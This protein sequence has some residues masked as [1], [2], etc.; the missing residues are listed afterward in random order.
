MSSIY[1]NKYILI[2]LYIEN[3]IHWFL[4]RVRKQPKIHTHTHTKHTWQQNTNVDRNGV[5]TYTCIDFGFA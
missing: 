2:E 1:T 3:Q 5:C 4:S